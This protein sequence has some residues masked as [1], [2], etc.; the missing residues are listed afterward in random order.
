MSELPAGQLVAGF[1]AAVFVVLG[2]LGVV[3]LTRVMTVVLVVS[4]LAIPTAGFVAYAIDPQPLSTDMNVILLAFPFV[5]VGIAA[6][7]IGIAER[8]PRRP[9]QSFRSVQ[10]SAVATVVLWGCLVAAIS[11]FLFLFEPQLALFNLFANGVWLAGWM[12][13][14]WRHLHSRKSIDIAVPPERV[15]SFIAEPAN[16]PQY[17]AGV[18][19]ASMSGPLAAGSRVT[20]RRRVDARGLHGPRFT[21]PDSVETTAEL[22]SVEPNR[23]IVSRSVEIEAT[24]TSEVDAVPGGTRLTMS[25]DRVIPYRLAILGVM[26]E[27]WASAG[28][29]SSEANR[30]WQRLKEILEQP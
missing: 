24:V 16:W 2:V 30:S 22:V 3:R 6:A 18:E 8:L 9:A 21:L 19:F 10:R 26:L 15:F 4:L 1:I 29:R 12:P 7:I 17:V 28:R 23:R 27:L 13:R 11:D 25:D 14:S 20:V 5:G